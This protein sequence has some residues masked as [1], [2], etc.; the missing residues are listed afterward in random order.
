MPFS[1]TAPCPRPLDFGDYS[2]FT[3]ASQTA[4][5]NL[6]I[7]SAATDGEAAN[8]ANATATGDDLVGDD[9]D[10]TMPSFPVGSPTNLV[11]PITNALRCQRAG[12]R[13][14]RLEWRQRCAG[15]Q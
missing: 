13:V 3:A 8:P 2:N 15:Y 6:R 9:E 10:L 14:C 4:N 11:V 7:G 5:T 1:A 12:D